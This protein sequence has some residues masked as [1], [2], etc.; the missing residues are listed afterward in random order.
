MVDERKTTSVNTQKVE[1]L[2]RAVVGNHEAKFRKLVVLNADTGTYDIM[3][4][5]PTPGS[6]STPP[7]ITEFETIFATNPIINKGINIRTNRLLA[8]GFKLQPVQSDQVPSAL[9]TNAANECEQFFN[10]IGGYTFW[11]QSIKNAYIAGN[12][13]TEVIYNKLDKVTGVAHGDYKT[14]DFRR[15]FITNK[16]LL[17]G[18]GKPV[19]YWQF[20]E[21]LMELYQSLSVLFG[22][23][24]QWQNLVAA[25]QRLMMTGGGFYQIQNSDGIPVAAVGVLT[26]NR[27]PT[28]LIVARKP[29]YMFLNNDEIVHLSFNNVNDN[30][31]GFSL[32]LGAY[33]AINQLTNIQFATAEAINSIGYP[34]PVVTH[35]SEKFPA[36]EI[37][38]TQAEVLI[39]DPVR[40]EG[41]V[42]PYPMTMSYLSSNI[43]ADIGS[44]PDWYVT[45]ACIGI[46]VPKET[47]VADGSSNRATAFS[48]STDFEKDI[49]SDRRVFEQYVRELASRFLDSRGYQHN[50][51]TGDLN[52]YTP[53]VKWD[54][55]ITEDAALRQKMATELWQANLI[56]YNDAM[57]MLGLPEEKDEEKGNMRLN[58]MTAPQTP[59]PDEAGLQ[60]LIDQN[61]PYTPQKDSQL[62][63]E[64]AKLEIDDDAVSGINDRLNIPETV[65]TKAAIEA[66]VGTKIKSVE[67]IS[68]VRDAIA[69][70]YA[71]GDSAEGIARAVMKTAN[72]SIDKAS[73]T[74]IARTELNNLINAAK[75]E[76]Q[77][78]RGF[79]HKTWHSHKDEKTSPLCAALD[80]QEVPIDQPFKVDYTDKDGKKKHWEGMQ[81]SA[82]PNCRSSMAF[83]SKQKSE[84]LLDTIKRL[85]GMGG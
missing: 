8:N 70:A 16:V 82:H 64:T 33:D 58:E 80:G 46:R 76:Q 37:S 3:N 53:T 6:A 35:G 17:D 28:N 55:L 40:K 18:N 67:N 42:L 22:S 83:S 74:R 26:D 73:A 4:P 14:I 50:S 78:D 11:R 27:E 59:S 54:E 7:S 57:K 56:K 51:A 21:N 65:G 34:K 31:F 9:A 1:D 60:T 39:Q 61:T 13:W 25:Q 15:S 63:K 10:G 75:L 19:G 24:P 2:T 23:V 32:I 45:A 44:Y 43:T 81:P 77:K 12:E 20:I 85:L 79:T 41:F 52:P 62:T 84:G 5:N 72:P 48:N 69:N 29:N 71:N 49:E 36:T 30:P 47:V 68:Q 38:A 66:K